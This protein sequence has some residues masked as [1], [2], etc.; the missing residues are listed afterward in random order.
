M[1]YPHF[2]DLVNSS[3]AARVKDYVD[4]YGS[5]AAPETDLEGLGLSAKGSE[6]LHRIVQRF[7]R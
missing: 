3:A 6:R 7:N 2:A 1:I 5:M 4:G